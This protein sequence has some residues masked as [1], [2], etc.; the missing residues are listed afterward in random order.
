MIKVDS[1]MKRDEIKRVI[2]ETF[3]EV[4]IKESGM[5]LTFESELES[6]EKA[7]ELKKNVKSD[8]ATSAVYCSVTRI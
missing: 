5:S 3:G 8:P 6:D 7:A 1:P 4:E 2:K